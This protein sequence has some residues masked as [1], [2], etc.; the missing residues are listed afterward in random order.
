[1]E[2]NNQNQDGNQNSLR[3]T[4]FNNIKPEG[5]G[6]VARKKWQLNRLTKKTRVGLEQAK[7]T[8]KKVLYF[9]MVFH[10]IISAIITSIVLISPLNHWYAHQNPEKIK[11]LRNANPQEVDEMLNS[12]K[13]VDERTTEERKKEVEKQFQEVSDAI[14]PGIKTAQA[15]APISAVET[16]AISGATIFRDVTAYNLVPGQTD[17]SPCIGAANQNLCYLMRTKKMNVCASNAYEFGTILRIPDYLGSQKDGNDTC[18]VLD[19]MA[20]KYSA[21]VDICMDRDFQRAL[22]FRTQNLPITVVGHLE[23]KV[24]RNLAPVSILKYQTPVR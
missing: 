22:A 17:D 18:V 13:R 21:R 19:R 10:I 1:M 5:L 11:T 12:Y 24:W 14:I 2:N 8:S 7:K 23:D 20:K 16:T 6:F 9:I 4:T 15:V 3:H